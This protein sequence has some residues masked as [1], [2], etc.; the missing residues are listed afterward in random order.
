MGRSEFAKWNDSSLSPE[1]AL[2]PGCI[3]DEHNSS[4]L[5]SAADESAGG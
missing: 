3:P 4:R 5:A 2:V 1:V